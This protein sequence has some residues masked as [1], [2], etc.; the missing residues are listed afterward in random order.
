[1]KKALKWILIVIVVC[2][3]SVLIALLVNEKINQKVHLTEYTYTDEKIP[4]SFDGTK[5]MFLS[6]LHNAPFDGQIISYAKK[7]QPDYFVMTGD[8]SQL[9]DTSVKYAL[10]IAYGLK[11]LDIPVYGVSGNHERQGGKYERAMEEFW[12]ADVCMLENSSTELTKNGEK[13]TLAGI[14]DPRHDVVTEYKEKVIKDNIAYELSKYPDN[15]SILLNHRADIYPVIKDTGV[16]LILSGHLHGGII[17]LPFVGG[18]IGKN[19]ENSLLPAYEYGMIKEGDSATMIVSGGCDKNPQK[20]RYFNPPELV[21][22][23]LKRK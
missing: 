6:D 22:I 1:M 13:I 21:L 9:P 2:I 18:I 5:I 14:K 15:F 7:I 20:K 11:E 4:L 23:T 8:M 16:D 12:A 19:G 17:K 3:V 10:D